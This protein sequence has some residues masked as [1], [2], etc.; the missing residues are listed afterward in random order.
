MWTHGIPVPM[1]SS[2]DMSIRER[3]AQRPPWLWGG[4]L[5]FL[6]A[7]GVRVRRCPGGVRVHG[8]RQTH[9]GAQPRLYLGAH[10]LVVHGYDEPV[11]HLRKRFVLDIATP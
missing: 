7:I 3:Q 10:G 4:T 8:Q 11:E 5:T 6:Q 1:F 2:R 9:G